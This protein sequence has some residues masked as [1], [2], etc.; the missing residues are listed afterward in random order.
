MRAFAKLKTVAIPAAVLA[1]VAASAGM[2]RAQDFT[3]SIPARYTE[4]CDLDRSDLTARVIARNEGVYPRQVART[5]G[6]WLIYDRYEQQVMELD[7]DLR[8]VRRWGRQGPGPME[9]EDPVGLG[10]LDS[11]R[12]VVVDASP[13]SLIL[14]GPGGTEHRLAIPARPTHAIV[15]DGTVLI[16]TIEATVHE[17]T[18]DGQVRT[19]NTRQDFGLRENRGSGAAAA[20]RL[21][22]N[23]M[24]FTGPSA[25][26]SLGTQPRRTIQRCVHDDLLGTLEEAVRIDTPFGPQPFNLTTMQDYLPLGAEGF[27]AL[28]GLVVAGRAGQRLRSIEHYDSSGRLTQAWQLLGYPAVRGV[29]DERTIGRMLVW[30][31]EEFDGIQLVEVEGL[32]NR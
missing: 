26:W 8:R 20:P 24:A 5:S 7:E 31:E 30:H 2:A 17:V 29:F 6:G 27:L 18:L 21:R 10:R 15:A 13:P 11:D 22:G 1:V 19:L 4:A 25:I 14:F 3:A 9:Y 28:G 23:H 32:V 12:V 16:A